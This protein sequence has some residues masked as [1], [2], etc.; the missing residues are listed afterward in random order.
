VRDWGMGI[1][2]DEQEKIFDRFHR[3]ST[4]LV[5]DVKGSGLGLAIVR[6]VVSA[7]GGAVEV[8]SRPGQGSTFSIRLPLELEKDWAAEGA[9]AAPAGT[10]GAASPAT[11]EGRLPLLGPERP[12]PR[13]A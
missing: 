6:H 11:G 9:S 4:G 13:E 12:R 1:P 5:H 8:D 3:V 10:A 2:R 7:H